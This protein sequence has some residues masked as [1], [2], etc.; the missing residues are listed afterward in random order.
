ML[1]GQFF[2]QKH[3]QIDLYSGTKMNLYSY[4]L[5]IHINSHSNYQSLIIQISSSDQ[6]L[7]F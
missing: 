4:I 2:Y 5:I 1:G 7:K 6:N 3:Y